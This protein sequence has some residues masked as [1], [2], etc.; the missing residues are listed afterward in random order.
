MLPAQSPVDSADSRQSSGHISYASGGNLLQYY[1]QS[2]A[3]TSV[4]FKEE[5]Q[6]HSNVGYHHEWSPGIHTLFWRIG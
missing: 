4:R 5:Q 2:D 6:T 3:N 1:D